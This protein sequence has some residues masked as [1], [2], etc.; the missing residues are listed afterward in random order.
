MSLRLFGIAICLGLVSL[1]GSQA[2][3]GGKVEGAIWKYEMH[4]IGK[5][6]VKRTGAF[7]IHGEDIF[8]P[9]ERKATKIGTIIG[10]PME[11]P[12]KGD[13][14]Q[15]TFS[16]LRGRDRNELKCKGRVTLISFGKVRGR[17][18]D[19][20]GTHWAFKADRVQE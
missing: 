17:L 12:Q 1:Q 3:D 18:V 14:V 10:K 15:I 8:Q 4:Q 20:E 19:S 9:R 16:A 2:Q 11:K 7:R 5:P 6:D 13:K